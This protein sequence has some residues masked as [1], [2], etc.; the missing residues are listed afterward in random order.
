MTDIVGQ[1][2][3]ENN[4]AMIPDPSKARAGAI[5][6]DLSH[7]IDL[8]R[9]TAAFAVVLAHAGNRLVQH[10]DTIDP[11]ERTIIQ[12]A[13]AFLMGF[14]HP[15][16][17]LFFVISGFLVG[18][19]ALR[20]VQR[21]G[22]IDFSR[23]LSRRLIRLWI[24]ILPALAV[25][26]VFDTAGRAIDTPAI[27]VY[28]SANALD[29]GTAL[30]NIA[31]LQ[32]VLCDPYGSDGA[33]WTLYNEFCYYI[34]FVALLVLL[35][36]CRRTPVRIAGFSAYIILAT[37]ASLLQREGVPMIPYFAIWLFGVWAATS[38]TPIIRLPAP[39]LLAAVIVLLLAY[40]T[41]VGID[42]IDHGGLITFGFDIITMGLFAG[43][44]SVLRFRPWA[45]P[46]WVSKPSVLLASFSFSLYCF[47]L[48]VMN[49]MAV[50]LQHYLGFGWSDVSHGLEWG[51]LIAMLAFVMVFAFAVS[52]L[53]EARTNSLRYLLLDRRGAVPAR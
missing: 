52:R 27:D 14:S 24:V 29:A 4:A 21:S 43:F 19:T 22:D 42:W 34:L 48:P 23:F 12:Y 40:R 28:V 46:T 16:I 3:V 11:G 45:L 17:M 13:Y 39:A 2:R 1:G 53:T 20:E 47:H 38:K 15:G 10:V 26:Y 50:G 31:F 49:L 37:L 7:W 6:E 41:L 9:W 5:N 33:L 25:T 51:R 32:T 30:C 44:L 35:R 18:G 8:F 36:G